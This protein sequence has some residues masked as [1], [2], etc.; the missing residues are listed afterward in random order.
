MRSKTSK[1]THFI[2][3]PPIFDNNQSHLKL[4]LDVKVIFLPIRERRN[5]HRSLG[6]PAIDV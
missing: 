1:S 4:D 2:V 5:L 3:T 6:L